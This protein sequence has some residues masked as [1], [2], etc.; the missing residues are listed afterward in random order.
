MHKVVLFIGI[1]KR[2]EGYRANLQFR[3]KLHKL[4][5]AI[6]RGFK[7]FFNNVGNVYPAGI[8]SYEYRV[9]SISAISTII[10]HFKN[11]PFIKTY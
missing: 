11:Y 8:N 9:T 4:D 7:A 6:L 1:T 2:T 5:K 3:F 10:S